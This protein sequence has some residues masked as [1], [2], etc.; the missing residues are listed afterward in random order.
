LAEK[1]EFEGMEDTILTAE[2]AVAALEH[3]LNDPDFQAKQFAE[4]PTLV[5]RLDAAKAE[6]ARL[7]HRWEELS[8]MV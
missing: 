4:I 7:Y 8:A 5:A 2:E 1:K 6:V 3:Q